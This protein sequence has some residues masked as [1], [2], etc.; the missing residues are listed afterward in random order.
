MP[1]V[2]DLAHSQLEFSVRHMMISTV[3]GRFNK[4]SGTLNINEAQL[5]ASSAE[6]TAE[7]ASINTN[8][9][10]RDTH[11]RSPD[12]FD[13][14][15]YPLMSFR[16]G[17]ITRVEEGRYKVAGLLTIR[18]VTREVVFDVS[19]EGFGK[20]PWGNRRIG[21]AAQATINRKDFGLTWNVALETGGWLVQDQVKI[22]ADLEAVY[23]AE[24]QSEPAQASS[25]TSAA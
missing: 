4:F 9:P 2:I 8:D 3:R 23:Q 15:K 7:T 10:N 12:F 22:S 1:W 11:L 19:M 21:L 16:S 24:A 6:G 20:D 18:D 25:E 17:K 14:E 13:A 5:E